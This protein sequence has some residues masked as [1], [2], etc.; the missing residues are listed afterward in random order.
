MYTSSRA[1]IFSSSILGRI[2]RADTF[3]EKLDQLIR[4]P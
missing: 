1:A 2:L 4:T 3:G